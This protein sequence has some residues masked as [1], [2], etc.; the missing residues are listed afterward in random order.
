MFI[1]IQAQPASELGG[2]SGRAE[3]VPGVSERVP[4][5]S[6][7]V[8]R[9]PGRLPTSGGK[10]I[11]FS[12]I[13][14]RTNLPP[15]KCSLPSRHVCSHFRHRILPLSQEN[16]AHFSTRNLSSLPKDRS[17]GTG[18]LILG[19]ID[20]IPPTFR[21]KRLLFQKKLWGHISDFSARA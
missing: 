8:P 18:E 15:E 5:V 3:R 12:I 2:Y 10:P 9:L 6:E 21:A 16:R 20:T 19:Y 7:R 14:T 1:H 11:T 4:G 13:H 17:P